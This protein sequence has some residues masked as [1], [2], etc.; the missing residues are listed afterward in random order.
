MSLKLNSKTVPDHQR[1]KI[2]NIAIERFPGEN[3]EWVD[4]DDLIGFA[5]L[6][7]PDWDYGDGMLR[8]KRSMNDCAADAGA[9]VMNSLDEGRMTMWGES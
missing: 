5:V 4:R 1:T 6:D 3:V 9:A 8:Q 2:E 7:I